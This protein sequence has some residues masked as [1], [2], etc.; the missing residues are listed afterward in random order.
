M[1]RLFIVF[2]FYFFSFEVSASK[3]EIINNFKKVNNL[4][5]NFDQKIN[6]KIESGKCII[7]YPNKILCNYNDFYQKVIVSNGKNILV[8]NNR[9]NL[10]NMYKLENTPLKILLDKIYLIEK[11]NEKD[12][13]GESENNFY[14]DINY[15]DNN[16]M[17]FFDKVNLG[18]KGWITTDIYQNT[19]ETKIDGLQ[20]NQLIDEDIFDIKNYMN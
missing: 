5:F 18:I 6:D 2:F 12:N 17:V 11:M 7:S 19:V 4:T 20:T 16:I 15:E 10:H 3:F 14:F 8:N 9:T 13:F 1:I